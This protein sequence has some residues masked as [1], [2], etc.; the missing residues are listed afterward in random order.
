MIV[1]KLRDARKELGR[2]VELVENGESVVITRR[3]REVAQMVRRTPTAA[4]RRLPSLKLFRKRIAVR[5]NAM[6]RTVELLRNEE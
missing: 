4:D 3:G 6:S 2:L 1:R 5:G